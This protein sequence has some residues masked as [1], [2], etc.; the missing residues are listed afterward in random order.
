MQITIKH[1]FTVEITQFITQQISV[2]TSTYSLTENWVLLFL[3]FK[4]NIWCGCWKFR[5][6]LNIVQLLLYRT[7]QI[8]EMIY[9]KYCKWYF[10]TCVN[11]AMQCFLG[12]PR[13]EDIFFQ[14]TIP[15]HILLLELGGSRMCLKR[16]LPLIE[17]QTVYNFPLLFTGFLEGS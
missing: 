14:F 5:W 1:L 13:Y 10:I 15:K 9:R 11:V 4:A 3:D 12:H 17:T 16:S 7:V 8:A 6:L 2:P